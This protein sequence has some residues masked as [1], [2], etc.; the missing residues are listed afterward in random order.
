[1]AAR[2]GEGQGPPQGSPQK[3]VW[4]RPQP[5]QKVPSLRRA[6]RSSLVPNGR[7]SSLTAAAEKLQRWGGRGSQPQACRR[8]VPSAGGAEKPERLRVPRG[9]AWPHPQHCTARLDTGPAQNSV[10]HV[11]PLAPRPPRVPAHVP[12]SPALRREGTVT[13][14]RPRGTPPHLPS[15]PECPLP[16]PRRV[17]ASEAWCGGTGPGTADQTSSRVPGKQGFGAGRGEP[18]LSAP[19]SG[20]ATP[21]H[22]GRQLTL[23]KLHLPDSGASGPSL[24]TQE[25]GG[26]QGLPALGG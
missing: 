22:S 12:W 20:P 6:P 10:Q 3:R 9:R 4:P 19:Q 11:W 13:A 14:H 17:V 26:A 1:M 5:G 2:S 24:P 15:S 21:H 16:G 7:K 23:L 25:E 18:K 8:L